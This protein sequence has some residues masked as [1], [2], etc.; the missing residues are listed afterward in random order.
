MRIP[1]VDLVA[2]YRDLQPRLEPALLS[3]LGAAQFILGPNVQ[4]FEKEAAS[5]AKHL[6]L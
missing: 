2:Q 4:A 1:M 3:T 6:W 5:I